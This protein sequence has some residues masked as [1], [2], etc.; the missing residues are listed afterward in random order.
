ME[1]K[2]IRINENELRRIINDT[3]KKAINEDISNANDPFTEAMNSLTEAYSLVS[4]ARNLFLESARNSNDEVRE[5]LKYF[6]NTIQKINTQIQNIIYFGE[7]DYPDDEI[8]ENFDNTKTIKDNAK[9]N[10]RFAMSLL[11]S[12]NEKQLYNVGQKVDGNGLGFKDGIIVN[13]YTENGYFYYEVKYFIGKKPFTKVLR[14][15]DIKIL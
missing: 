9:Q 5:M 15:K 7:S 3:I 2:L 12:G 6:Q 11:T 4:K 13:T 8:F 10:E 14:Q 1:K